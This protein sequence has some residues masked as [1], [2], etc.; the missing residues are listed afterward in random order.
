MAAIAAQNKVT[1]SPSVSWFRSNLMKILRHLGPKFGRD[2]MTLA[3][4]SAAP[5]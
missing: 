4:L 5:F 1:A 3:D 2:E